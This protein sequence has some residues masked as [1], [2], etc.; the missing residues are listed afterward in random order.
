[1]L[2]T[3]RTFISSNNWKQWRQA[4]LH[5]RELDLDTHLSSGLCLHFLVVF[6]WLCL[7]PCSGLIPRLAP[8]MTAWF[9]PA[10]P[11]FLSVHWPAEEKVWVPAFPENIL[12]IPVSVISPPSWPLP[13]PPQPITVAG[14]WTKLL[15]LAWIAPSPCNPT[16]PL[17]RHGVTAQKPLGYPWKS[18]LDCGVH[19]YF[20]RFD[21]SLTRPQDPDLLRASVAWI[22]GPAPIRLVP[23]SHTLSPHSSNGPF[24]RN[25]E[26]IQLQGI[27]FCP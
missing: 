14:K 11:A 10:F 4:E 5:P 22:L 27:G 24:G 16:Q 3:K 6:L 13:W 2:N 18:G 17:S 7:G 9:T 1:M 19:R 12:Q 21:G 25:P 8:I 20:K 26:Y 23:W 15:V